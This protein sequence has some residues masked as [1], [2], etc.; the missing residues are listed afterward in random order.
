VLG[1]VDAD[2][3]EPA[4]VRIPVARDVVDADGTVA[5]PDVRASLAAQLAT[6]AEHV[7]SKGDA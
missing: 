5:D 7:R 1:Y 4:C 3:I 6:V 2:V